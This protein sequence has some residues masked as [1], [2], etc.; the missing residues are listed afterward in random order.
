MWHLER[1]YALQRDLLLPSKLADAA[2]DLDDG[3][4]VDALEIDL[5]AFV[6]GTHQIIIIH[7]FGYF[8]VQFDGSVYVDRGVD[9]R[10]II[11]RLFSAEYLDRKTTA[12]IQSHGDAVRV[13]IEGDDD[14]DKADPSYGMVEVEVY[15]LACDCVS[16]SMLDRDHWSP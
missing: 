10:C 6:C 4:K 14:A 12:I 3:A 8:S 15:I 9:G 7:R 11:D 2:F 1:T 13:D 16:L 5:V